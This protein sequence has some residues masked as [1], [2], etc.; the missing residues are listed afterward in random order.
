MPI[1]SVLLTN[2]VLPFIHC[3]EE[4]YLPGEG[5]GQEWPLSVRQIWAEAI[6][7]HKHPTEG[8]LMEMVVPCAAAAYCLLGEQC[9][10]GRLLGLGA[11]VGLTLSVTGFWQL[12]RYRR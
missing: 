1:E 10:R 7:D 12:L 5:E 3:A 9:S 11:G 6:L 4:A 2:S 8:A